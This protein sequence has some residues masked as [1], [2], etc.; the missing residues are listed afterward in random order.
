MT[1]EDQARLTEIKD[2]CEWGVAEWGSKSKQVI[3]SATLI[4][5]LDERKAALALL[6]YAEDETDLL[7]NIKR[8][9]AHYEQEL[10]Y[11]REGEQALMRYCEAL[12]DRIDPHLAIAIGLKELLRVRKSQV[13]TNPEQRAIWERSRRH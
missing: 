4:A 5:L 9:K 6:G 7:E 8:L 11:A 1:P 13:P 2:K 3:P 10:R 12:Q